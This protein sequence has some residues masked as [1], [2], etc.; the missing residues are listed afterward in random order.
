MDCLTVQSESN[1]IAWWQ[2]WGGCA[3]GI[4]CVIAPLRLRSRDVDSSSGAC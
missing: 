3:N 1:R 4:D 2:A